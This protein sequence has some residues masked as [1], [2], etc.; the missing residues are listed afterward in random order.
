MRLDSCRK[1]GAEMK[2]NKRCEV[3]RNANQFLCL[4]CSDITDEQ[5]HATCRLA[6]L[7]QNL[8]KVSAA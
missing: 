2:I 4:I 7:D 1:C 8:P 3:C 6:S 5:I